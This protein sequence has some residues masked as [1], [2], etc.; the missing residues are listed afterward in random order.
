MDRVFDALEQNG[1][2]RLVETSPG[3]AIFKASSYFKRAVAATTASRQFNSNPEIAY[4]FYLNE[5]L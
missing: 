5:G 2:S 1:N 3:Y 4:V